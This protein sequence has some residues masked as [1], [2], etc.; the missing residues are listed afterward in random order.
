MGLTSAWHWILVL[1][2]LAILF[3]IPIAATYRENSGAKLK[4]R[5]FAVWL[6]GIIALGLVEDFVTFSPVAIVFGIAWLLIAYLFQ[7]AV[8]RRARDAGFGKKVAYYATIPLVNIVVCVFLL[9]KPS[10]PNAE[11]LSMATA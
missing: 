1:L 8:V 11:N 5:G 6:I 3:G 9:V 10:K 2:V 7:Q 4:R